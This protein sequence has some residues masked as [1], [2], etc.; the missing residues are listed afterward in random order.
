MSIVCTLNVISYIVSSKTACDIII[1]YQDCE[2]SHEAFVNKL[3]WEKRKY[4]SSDDEAAEIA[5]GGRADV[6]Y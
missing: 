3:T 1:A 4:V 2:I 5:T 6:L